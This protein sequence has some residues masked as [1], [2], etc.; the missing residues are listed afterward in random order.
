MMEKTTKNLKAFNTFA[1]DCTAEAYF[2]FTSKEQLPQTAQIYAQYPKTHILGGGSNTVFL[3]NRISGAVIRI[4]NKGIETLEENDRN[5]IVRVAAGESWEGFV[6]WACKR[7]YC[8]IENLAAI[9]GTVGAA[10]VQNI[11]AYGAQAEDSIAWVESFDMARQKFIQTKK[12]DCRFGYRN[13]RWKSENKQELIHSVVFSLNKNFVPNT[14]Y[15]ALREYM[16]RNPEKN[17]T[18]ERICEIVTEIRNSKLPDPKILGNAG[19]FFKNPTVDKDEYERLKSKFKNLVAF[20][21]QDGYKLSAAWLI[22]S[23]GLKGKRFG[24]VGMHE[25]QA[26]VMVNY[27]GATG[28]QIAD[29][30][31]RVR[32]TVKDR[33]DVDLQTEAHMVE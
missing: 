20:E 21:E 23:C 9:P 13:S 3:N 19:S 15:K 24:N 26:L 18:P 2:E 14:D 5:V 32:Q 27:G 8:G 6:R 12:E 17:P 4:C 10:P 25:K 7:G 11:G 28:K 31:L 33:F 29:F 1:I 16:E 22:E 30:A